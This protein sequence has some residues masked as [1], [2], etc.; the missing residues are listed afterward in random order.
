MERPRKLKRLVSF[1]PYAHFTG[2]KRAWSETTV[3]DITD[4]DS[5]S[6]KENRA[7]ESD[8]DELGALFIL[9]A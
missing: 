6:D 5:D 7:P 2:T 9:I 8:A 4:S 3:I 1:V